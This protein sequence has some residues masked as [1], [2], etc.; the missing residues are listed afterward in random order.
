MYMYDSFNILYDNKVSYVIDKNRNNQIVGE[1]SPQN[2]SRLLEYVYNIPTQ[3]V[4]KESVL[5]AVRTRSRLILIR[6]ARTLK[7]LK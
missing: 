7:C 5:A 6:S 4:D 3:A 1:M 2:L